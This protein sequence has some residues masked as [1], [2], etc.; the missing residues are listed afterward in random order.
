MIDEYTFFVVS[1]GKRIKK[2]KYHNSIFVLFDTNLMQNQ[3]MKLNL[4]KM[5]PKKYFETN[6]KILHFDLRLNKMED[7]H[8]RN[9][10]FYI[11]RYH[12]Y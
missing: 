7:L 10:I 4:I 9:F 2:Y 3:V 12:F 5:L 6:L 1:K 11:F 8:Y